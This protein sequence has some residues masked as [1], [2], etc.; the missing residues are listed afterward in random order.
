MSLLTAADLTNANRDDLLDLLT[1]YHCLKEG[2]KP[3]RRHRRQ[4][5]R[6]YIQFDVVRLRAMAFAFFGPREESNG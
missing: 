6:A 1:V 2:A 5:K 4:V 3:T